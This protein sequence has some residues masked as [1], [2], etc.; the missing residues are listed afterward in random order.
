MGNQQ[1]TGQGNQQAPYGQQMAN[2]LPETLPELFKYIS[3]DNTPED[4]V[5]AEIT[6]WPSNRPH[7]QG[8]FPCEQMVDRRRPQPGTPNAAKKQ[9][10]GGLMQTP[11]RDRGGARGSAASPAQEAGRD[12]FKVGDLVELWSKSQQTWCRGS[13]DKVEGSWVHIAYASSEGQ[14]MTKI[15][16]NGHEELRVPKQGNE[17]ANLQNMPMAQSG[18]DPSCSPPPRPDMMS[19]S[20]ARSPLHDLQSQ[21]SPMPPEAPQEQG[22]PTG[23]LFNL[24]GLG[25][26]DLLRIGAPPSGPGANS[27][28]AFANLAGGMDLLGSV[29]MQRQQRPAPSTP[30]GYEASMGLTPT[31]SS[32]QAWQGGLAQSPS[33]PSHSLSCAPG[34]LGGGPASQTPTRKKYVEP[35]DVTN[36]VPLA[37]GVERIEPE[38]VHQMLQSNACVLV[39]LRGNDRAVGLIPGSIHIQAI[40]ETPFMQK[41]PGMLQRFQSMPLVV[42]TCQYSAHRA[43]QCANWYREAADPRQRVAILSGGF[44]AWEGNGLPVETTGTGDKYAADAYALLQGVQFVHKAPGVGAGLTP[45]RWV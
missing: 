27:P 12:L 36:R 30:L 7:G 2:G 32:P 1:A 34:A 45:Q 14:P 11:T 5:H 33:Q 37:S 6:S 25:L 43:P 21:Q 20:P 8:G 31:Q 9:S 39:D 18:W 16:P 23:G 38:A 42:F 24:P 44:R 40:D 3:C 4:E 13:I 26:P 28:D 22:P 35:N 41:I 15:M 19:P 29:R 17:N 10:A